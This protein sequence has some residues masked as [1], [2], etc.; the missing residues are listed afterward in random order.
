MYQRDCTEIVQH[1]LQSPDGLYDV[2]EFTLCTIN[3][4]LSRVIEQR[5]SIKLHGIMSKWVSSTK[6]QGITYA[7][8]HK[9]ELH[10]LML[11]IRETAGCDTIDGAQAV[12]DLF[13][14]IPSI[15]MVKAGFIGQMLGFQVACLDR[16][17]VRALGL[18][19]S[20]LRINKKASQ[21]VR[22]KK[23][24]EYVKLCRRKGS[25]YWWDTWCNFVADRG[26]MN[27]SLPTGDAVSRYH[28]DAVVMT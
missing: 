14:R 5:K 13:M 27:K 9:V 6:A 25:E 23:I 28:V 18:S 12:V 24:R 7:Q 21:E 26:G 16:H 20:A 19:E 4:P 3:M 15:G 10:T 8:E 1:A 2:I 22:L 11:N 17:N